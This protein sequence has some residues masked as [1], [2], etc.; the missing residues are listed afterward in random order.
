MYLYNNTQVFQLWSSKFNNK[1]KYLLSLQIMVR[2]ILNVFSL[3][4]FF[5]SFLFSLSFFF[6][7]DWM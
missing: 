5:L 2:I 7:A 1:I 6:L 3:F 4:V